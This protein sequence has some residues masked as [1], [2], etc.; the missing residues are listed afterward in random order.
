VLYKSRRQPAA[1]LVTISTVFLIFPA[2]FAPATAQTLD[3]L[4]FENRF[5]FNDRPVLL[6]QEREAS[7]VYPDNTSTDAQPKGDSEPAQPSRSLLR[8]LITSPAEA[9]PTPAAPAPIAVPFRKAGTADVVTPGKLV[10]R[11]VRPIG[12]GRAAWYEHPGRT[13]SGE[14]FDPD[15]LTAAH[16]TL[17]FGTRLR[18]VNLHNG[19]AVV[20]RINDRVPRTTKSIMIDL[21]RGSARAVGIMG[22]GSVAL[23]QLDGPR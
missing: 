1:V 23:Y 15:R 5:H 21:S 18:V 11:R 17:P 14:T 10:T 2:A 16:K 9:A 12:S 19:R 4:S 7:R 13:A 3:S 8:N 22:V 6:P 20:V